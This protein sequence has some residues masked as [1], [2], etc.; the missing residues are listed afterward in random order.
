MRVRVPD[1]NKIHAAI[2]YEPQYTL[3]DILQEVIRYF[4]E[5]PEAA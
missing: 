3:D 2:G 4:K 5:H 1:L